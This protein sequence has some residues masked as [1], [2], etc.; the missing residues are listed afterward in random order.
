MTSKNP[1]YA[2]AKAGAPL[3]R[4]EIAMGALAPDDVEIKVGY[5][6][7]CHSDLSMWKNDWGMTEYPFIGGHE[8]IGTVVAKG[9]NVIS[10]KIGDRVGVGWNASSC[11]HCRHC[12]SGG[13]MFCA[14]RT[15][16]IVGRSGG[17]ADRV[18]CDWRWAI[19]LPENL[20]PA[21][22]GP[23]FCGGV[24]VFN[25][26][27]QLGIR[28]TDR[29]GVI[30]IGGLGHLALQFADKW[31]CEVTAF[32][33]DKSKTSEARKLGADHV[34][35]S[36]AKGA[37]EKLKG[38]FDLIISTVNVN[39]DWEA[40]I[41]TLAPK[42]RLHM[43]GVVP[44]PVPVSVG[45]LLDNDRGVT[46]SGTGSPQIVSRMLDFCA[47]HGIAPI[48]EHFRMSQINE[49]FARLESGKARYRIVLENDF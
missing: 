32:T 12:M 14:D 15:A 18:R 20:D 29:V 6:G 22:A 46:G 24:T 17:F 49:A 7:L 10:L 28:P 47:R 34:V 3:K 30:G 4:V 5:C 31:G 37:L 25:P 36:R 33:S 26:L 9:A 44:E 13:H 27:D 38:T 11:G 8:A 42:G 43:V 1:A 39:L 35:D 41:Q 16:T 2:A 45:S 48:T 40:Y 23:L 19:R 21:K